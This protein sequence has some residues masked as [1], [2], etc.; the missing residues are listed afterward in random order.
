MAEKYTFPNRTDVIVTNDYDCCCSFV[1]LFFPVNSTY[2]SLALYGPPSESLCIY[3]SS[4]LPANTTLH[5]NGLGSFPNEKSLSSTSRQ[6]V[7]ANFDHLQR[8]VNVFGTFLLLHSYG[9]VIAR[10]LRII[11]KIIMDIQ[12][13]QF[14][15][16]FLKF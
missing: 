1:R 6:S 7:C 16:Y 10:L 11:E 8:Y 4:V 12:N 14:L 2:P 5:D 9:I 3:C 15:F 13:G